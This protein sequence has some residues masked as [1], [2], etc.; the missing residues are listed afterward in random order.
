MKICRK[1]HTAIPWLVALAFEESRQNLLRH[2]D[3]SVVQLEELEM[4]VAHRIRSLYL[5]ATQHTSGRHCPLLWRRYMAFEVLEYMLL[6]RAVLSV[7]YY[8]LHILSL[9]IIYHFTSCYCTYYVTLHPVTVH[10]TIHPVT[11]HNISLYFLL[12]YICHFTSCH[13]TYVTIH[14]D[15]VHVTIHPVTVQ[16][17]AVHKSYYYAVFHMYIA[18]T[19][20][21]QSC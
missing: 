8:V 17:M 7:K 15:T 4:G 16:R 2:R 10:V 6:V 12:L 3:V 1:A 13:C 11:V 19:W 14:P 9:Y 5:R 18:G 21:T 20:W